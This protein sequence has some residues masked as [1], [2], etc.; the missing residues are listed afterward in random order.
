MKT[1]YYWHVALLLSDALLVLDSNA[2]IYY[3]SLGKWS[4]LV[5][6]AKADF[7]KLKDYS[8][9]PG[10]PKITTQ[11][12]EDVLQ[13]IADAL[14][15][16]SEIDTIRAKLRYQ[17]IFG[18]SFQRKA[19][20]YLV[21]KIPVGETSVYSEV[22][23]KLGHP[24]GARAVGS[25]CGANKIALL[26]PCHRVVTSSNTITGYRWGPGLKRQLL[27][28]ERVSDIHAKQLK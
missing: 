19:W 21:E 3:L 23:E 9:A 4:K 16:P 13:R 12:V 1:L 28:A 6:V 15:R 24:K 11:Q 20:D 2:T 17:Y 10:T 25:A 22:A 7:R 5:D 18:T 8:L 27:D 26:V 14:E